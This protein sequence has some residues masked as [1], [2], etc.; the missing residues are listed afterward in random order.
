MLFTDTNTTHSSGAW[1]AEL[2]LQ[3]QGV[4]TEGMHLSHLTM[5]D[6]LKHVKT[7]ECCCWMHEHCR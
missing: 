4:C 5:R 1:C 2:I 7:I 3:A 6:G